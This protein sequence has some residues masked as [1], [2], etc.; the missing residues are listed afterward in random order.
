MKVPKEWIWEIAF[1]AHDKE[2]SGLWISAQHP[3][4][5]QT[6]LGFIH[7]QNWPWLRIQLSPL[8]PR[9]QPLFDHSW[10]RNRDLGIRLLSFKKGYYNVNVVYELKYC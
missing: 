9:R 5:R 7:F 6:I 2:D 3:S 8:K 10:M 1:P 4:H